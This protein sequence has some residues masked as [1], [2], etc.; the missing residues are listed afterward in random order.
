[1]PLCFRLEQYQ[2]RTANTISVTANLHPRQIKM[3]EILMAAFPGLIAQSKEDDPLAGWDIIE[4]RWEADLIVSGNV[5]SVAEL[6]QFLNL[7][8][9]PRITVADNLDESHCLD[10]H[11]LPTGTPQQYER[12]QIGEMVFKAKYRG[13]QAE[14]MTIGN[15]LMEFIQRHPRYKRAEYIGSVPR[16]SSIGWRKL[17]DQ[18]VTHLASSLNKTRVVID[19]IK[20]VTSQK[21][22]SDEAE[23]YSRQERTMICQGNLAGRSVILV[24]D[25]YGS[26]GSVNEAARALRAAGA[27]EV[28]GLAATKTLKYTRG[29]SL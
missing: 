28:L 15:Q 23:R 3:P 7:F 1:M 11:D 5:P 4:G 29:V 25:M 24:D 21:D 26:G 2:N 20:P 9:S 19:R 17:A 6:D 13:G 18:L 10:F 22:V 14:Q 12:T 27:P 16:S 8:V